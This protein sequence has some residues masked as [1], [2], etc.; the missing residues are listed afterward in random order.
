[1]RSTHL[2]RRALLLAALLTFVPASG[3]MAGGTPVYAWSLSFSD[4]D[5]L[6]NEGPALAGFGTVYLWL[7]C[8]ANDGA[9]AFGG[10]VTAT[11]GAFLAGFTPSASVLNAGT[12]TDLLLAVGGCPSGA[13]LVGSFT[14]IG[15]A[16]DMCIDNPTTVNCDLINPIEFPSA[17]TGVS[18]GGGTVCEFGNVFCETGPTS[19]EESS[20]GSIKGLYR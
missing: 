3:A 8:S 9:A 4:T 7:S 17:F 14:V 19:V 6:A 18:A 16:T 1:M 12:A 20:W 10:H 5:P 2:S 11:G 13:Y 15:S